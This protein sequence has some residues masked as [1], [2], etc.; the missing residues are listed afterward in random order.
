MSYLPCLPS[1]VSVAKARPYVAITISLIFHFGSD[2][3][4]CLGRR[5]SAS[6][7]LG[8]LFEGSKSLTCPSR[9]WLLKKELAVDLV[10]TP[11]LLW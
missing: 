4:V 10:M 5:A 9:A 3:R 11:E 7:S 2:V 8:L 1:C 6:G